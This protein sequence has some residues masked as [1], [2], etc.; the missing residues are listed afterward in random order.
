[1]SVSTQIYAYVSAWRSTWNQAKYSNAQ[2]RDRNSRH[3]FRRNFRKCWLITR[4][5]FFKYRSLFSPSVRIENRSQRERNRSRIRYRSSM[6]WK[7]I[8]VVVSTC[9]VIFQRS[10]RTRNG[11]MPFCVKRSKF[12]ALSLQNSECTIFNLSLSRYDTNYQG[13]YLEI[14]KNQ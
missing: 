8:R 14:W 10:Q 13:L 7:I 1:M 5:S 12:S 9:P 4:H 2:H 6:N 11:K 3:S